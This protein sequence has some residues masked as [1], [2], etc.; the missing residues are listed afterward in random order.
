[1]I[2]EKRFEYIIASLKENG[3]ISYGTMAAELKVSEDTIRRDIDYLH[4]HGLLTKVRGGAIKVDKNPLSFSDREEVQYSEKE[5]IG[6]KVQG[7]LKKGMT[8]FMDGGTTVCSIAT[9]FPLD[10][11]FRIITNNQALVPIISRF[12]DIELIVLG[13][14]YNRDAQTNVGA[15]T[16]KDAEGF[17]VDIYLM[18]TCAI[19]REFGITAA[20]REDGAVK[21]AML[22]G[23]KKVIVVSNSKK[24]GTNEVFRVC[25]LSDIDVVVT[26]LPKDDP[27][28]D[29]IR[30]TDLKII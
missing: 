19:S 18:G 20:I 5:K 13:G 15:Q 27:Q 22:K 4:Q 29:P 2:K 10:S 24:I 8:I 1:M 3:E 12:K 6:L 30:Y 28:L 23:A 9:N 26:E 25:D 11:A 16:C 14:V 21:Q 17:V 7:L